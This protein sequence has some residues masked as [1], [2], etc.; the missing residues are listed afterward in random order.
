MGTDRTAASPPRG[1]VF[2][3]SGEPVAQAVQALGMTEAT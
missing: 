2:T 1:G 3:R